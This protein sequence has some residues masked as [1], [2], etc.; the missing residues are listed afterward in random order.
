MA[1]QIRRGTDAERQLFI[2]LQGEIIF[3]TDTKKLYVGDGT[4]VGGIAVDTVGEGGEPDSNTTYSISAESV[5]GGV[6]LRLTGSDS[7]IDNVKLAAGSN[8]TISRTDADTITIASTGVEG[9][10]ALNDLT[11]VNVNS[12][13]SGQVL[14]FNGTN[15]INSTSGGTGIQ[16][17]IEDSTPQL[18]GNLDL[19]NFDITGIGDIDLI[20]SINVDQINIGNANISFLSSFSGYPAIKLGTEIDPNRVLIFNNSE[21]PGSLQLYGVEGNNS[22]FFK[23]YKNT[24]SSPEIPDVAS[25]VLDLS[26]FVYTGHSIPGLEANYAK[27][28]SVTF[29]TFEGTPITPGDGYAKGVFIASIYENSA[30]D[31]FSALGL[32]NKTLRTNVPFLP[33]QFT[34]DDRDDIVPENGMLIY[35]TTVNKFQGY[36]N[37]VWVNL[38]TGTPA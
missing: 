8:V 26:S 37:G 1:L 28:G 17:V 24:A 19:N 31:D 16:N 3:T 27:L 38:D 34:D 36:Q 29:E 15:W 6:N 25:T 4:T 14:S 11:D 23:T 10:S 13:S 30:G 32:E 2:P 12:P 7:S 20:G 9:A 22:L 21:I 5:T 33:G 18:G 35:N